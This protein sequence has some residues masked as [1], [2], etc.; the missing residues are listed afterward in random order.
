LK[1]DDPYDSQYALPAH[2]FKAGVKFC[3]GTFDVEFARNVPFEAAAAAAFGLP[4]QEALKGVTIHAAEIFGV[5][6]QVGSIEK[7]K[8]AD[9]ILTDGDPL[10]AKTSIKA[11]FIAGKPVSLESRHTRLYQK[12][13]DRP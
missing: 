11:E 2:L 8:L 3:F 13:K 9:L 12:W 7:G 6:D 4:P 10:E 1:E 5:A